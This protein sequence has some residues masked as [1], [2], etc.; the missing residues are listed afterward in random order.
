MTRSFLL[1]TLALATTRVLLLGSGATPASAQPA[2]PVN[3][4]PPET[5]PKQDPEL[6]EA[7]QRLFQE[8]DVNRPI[9]RSG[10]GPL[11]YPELPRA[12]VR[13][14]Q[15]LIQLN[16]PAAAR[17]QLELAIHDTPSDPEPYIILGEIAL[18]ERRIFEAKQDFNEAKRVLAAYTNVDRKKI[19]EQQVLSGFAL[20][21]EADKDWKLANGNA[22]KWIGGPDAMASD[23]L[24][25]LQVATIRDLENG[26]LADAKAQAEAA[27]R[28]EASDPKKYSHS[29]VGRMLRGLV[30]LWEKNWPE[31]E[32]Y[33]QKIILE[34]PN[35]FAARNN[36]ALALVE[37]NDPDKR[38]RALT[39]AEANYRENK[40]S[41]D[42]LSTLGWVRFRR[43]EFDQAGLALDQCLKA[44]G[45]TLTN[46][47]ATYLAYVLYH[48]DR[49]WQ[50]RE[51]L[52]GIL[53]SDQPFSMR[54]EAKELYEKVKDEKR[55]PEATP[56]K[57]R[58]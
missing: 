55:S 52:E 21:A 58:R 32:K 8:R 51:I 39:Y 33:F 6:Q 3:P 16:Q 4:T 10:I 45:G 26:K 27:L 13:M 28:I 18:R 34:N 36:L 43:H 24:T 31:A 48:Q 20:L 40:N 25:T 57:G 1:F 53:K 7:L 22:E 15:F 14:Y 50:A 23:H 54:P 9:W 5:K 29:N 35:D 47:V 38:R 19:L 2:P 46:D 41:P 12:H 11:P 49:K 42:A 56:A 37:Q 30:A 44:T 17:F